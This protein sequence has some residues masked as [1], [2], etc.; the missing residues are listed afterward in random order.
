M[1]PMQV[2]AEIEKQKS[3]YN[4]CYTLQMYLG[5]LNYFTHCLLQ[6]CLRARVVLVVLGRHTQR[7]STF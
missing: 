7:P 5:T 4:L 6:S 2:I 1:T 3:W